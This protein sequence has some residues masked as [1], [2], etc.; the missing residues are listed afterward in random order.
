MHH[1]H[2]TALIT[3]NFGED[4]WSG[5]FWTARDTDFAILANFD[6][7]LYNMYTK[8]LSFGTFDMSCIVATVGR[9]FT[10]KMNRIGQVVWAAR[11][12]TFFTKFWSPKR[13]TFTYEVPEGVGI[14]GFYLIPLITGLN[15]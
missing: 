6:H 11:H 10:E 14:F 5:S 3:A 8:A 13:A 9:I 4:W 12:G 1:W 2:P 15:D 7:I